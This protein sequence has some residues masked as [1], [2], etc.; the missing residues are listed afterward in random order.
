MI[1]TIKKKEELVESLSGA[2]EG[3]KLLIEQKIIIDESEPEKARQIAQGKFEA[4]KAYRET[5]KIIEELKIEITN[6]RNA[7]EGKGQAAAFSGVEGRA[8]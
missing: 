3:Y 7:K 8:K 6:E 5:L 1:D 4:T 2:L